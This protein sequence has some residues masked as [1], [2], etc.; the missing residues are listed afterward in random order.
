MANHCQPRSQGLSLPAPKSERRETLVGSGHVP[1]GQMRTWGRGRLIPSIL[2][3]CRLSISKRAY[4]SRAPTAIKLVMFY[5]SLQAAIS[6]SIYSNKNFKV[7]QVVCLEAI[8]HGRDVVAILP[9]GYGKSMIFRLLPS[10]FLDKIK[11]ESPVAPSPVIIVVSP[12]NALFSRSWGWGER[13]PGNEVEPLW[14]WFVPTWLTL[15]QVF[16]CILHWR[17]KKILALTSTRVFSFS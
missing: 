15:V 3:R 13:D 14:A 4:H 10:L 8:Y 12:L 11:C 1:P 16:S 5:S 2:S 17:G 6:N 9:T 7:K